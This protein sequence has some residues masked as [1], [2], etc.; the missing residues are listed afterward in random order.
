[1]QIA[2]ASGGDGLALR[3]RMISAGLVLVLLTAIVAPAAMPRRSEAFID[4]LLTI[5][6]VL[7]V[8]KLTQGLVNDTIDKAEGAAKDVMREAAAQISKLLQQIESTYGDALNTT[9]D[10]LDS[11][12]GQQLARLAALFDQINQKLMEDVAVIQQAVIDLLQQVNQM[13]QQVLTRLE[14]LIVVGVRGATFVIDKTTYN[15]AFLIAVVLLAIGL[16]IFT[17]LLWKGK[18]PK[19][20]VRV[21]ALSFM[22]FY[23][24]LFSALLVPQTRVY[25]ITM[26][27]QA[28]K[29]KDIGSGARIFAVT[30]ARVFRG[31]TVD[32]TLVGAHFHVNGDPMVV[33][34]GQEV[35]P[36][37]HSDTHIAVRLTG[38]LANLS[39]PQSITVK[40][41]DGKQSSPAIVEFA[42]PPPPS[43]ITSWRLVPS[44]RAYDY[45][46][47]A[48]VAVTCQS[49]ALAPRSF[50]K[51]ITV[52]AGWEL[53]ADEQHRGSVHAGTE[54]SAP[55]PPL[56]FSESNV[57]RSG[58][59]VIQRV[60]TYSPS[61]D[62][63]RK[64]GIRVAGTCI[65]PF[66]GQT[67]SWS[68]QY[69]VW[70][71][72]LTP[73]DGSP[74]TGGV[75]LAQ[76]TR[77]CGTYPA[78]KL[79]MFRDGRPE[80][81]TLMVTIRTPSGQTVD[82]SAVFTPGTPG[83]KLTVENVSIWM[84]N[85]DLWVKGPGGNLIPPTLILVPIKPL[86]LKPLPIF[87]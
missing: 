9:L 3:V 47:F 76:G 68:A 46:Q 7:G 10:S 13:V 73:K 1:M 28:D 41:A 12:T 72:K 57:Q 26:V 24:L 81:Y 35:A 38:A 4:I 74:V 87:R 78:D 15:M 51:Q 37:A 34:A 32:L 48:P 67:L 82:R 45:R 69:T 63:A 18:V 23:I 33:I 27:G 2:Q 54:G 36:Q 71:R 58:N 75:C 59:G 6:G 16:L 5:G 49:S 66:F 65:A 86:P 53:A 52:E 21:V 70:G 55:N 22:A 20:W 25:A 8:G 83:Q 56:G 43:Q 84:E 17:G 79:A 11:F 30:P 80:A 29:L 50:D 60:I 40:T 77:K 39:G 64:D 62:A 44:G 61:N 19:G 42:S 85:N 14:D 31:A